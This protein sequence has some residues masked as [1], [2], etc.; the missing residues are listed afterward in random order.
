MALSNADR[1]RAYRQR[2]LAGVEG[3]R[4]RLN[5]IV[6]QDAVLALR[7][8]AAHKGQSQADT[9]RELILSAQNRVTSN[10]RGEAWDKYHSVE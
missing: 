7:R 10:M 1:Q 3:T 9:L 5:M 8:L 2:H 4:A 6:E